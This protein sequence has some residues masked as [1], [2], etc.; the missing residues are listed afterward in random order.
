MLEYPTIFVFV[1]LSSLRVSPSP[2]FSPLC[3]CLWGVALILVSTL[4]TCCF[5]VLVLLCC[6]NTHAT[7]PSVWLTSWT[8]LSCSRDQQ[9]SGC[10]H[11]RHPPRRNHTWITGVDAS[12]CGLSLGYV[13]GAFN[14]TTF[15]VILWGSRRPSLLSGTLSKQLNITSVHCSGCLF[16]LRQRLIKHLDF[17]KSVLINDAA[18]LE[19]FSI[20]KYFILSMTCLS[21]SASHYPPLTPNQ[22]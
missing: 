8:L 4:G 2:C 21:F 17:I 1:S 12:V 3:R 6:C 11:E 7:L 16:S 20:M 22:S 10:L 15:D 14:I 13:H 5:L 19:V 9:L 18:L